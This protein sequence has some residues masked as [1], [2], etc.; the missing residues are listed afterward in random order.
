MS[1][2]IQGTS[3]QGIPTTYAGARF[4]SRL[5]ARWAAFFDLCGWRWDYEPFDLDG[6]IP[7]F[8]LHGKEEG[9]EDKS[10]IKSTITLVEIK[11]V[12]TLKD[13]DG[14]SEGRKAAPHELL[15]LGLGPQPFDYWG[16]GRTSIG[17]LCEQYMPERGEG[18]PYT[19][20]SFYEAP[21]GVIPGLGH[22]KTGDEMFDFCHLYG[23]YRCR[24]SGIY[25]GD[26]SIPS[27]RFET[28][29]AMWRRAGNLVQWKAR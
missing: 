23:S 10:R 12:A 18:I 5:E 3:N 2:V 22:P 8:A 19:P 15:L 6:W 11:P 25:D 4:R 9:E 1:A 17:W 21:F 28:A 13:H 27:I 7:D 20:Y 26:G 24:I 14:Q 16:S 29:E